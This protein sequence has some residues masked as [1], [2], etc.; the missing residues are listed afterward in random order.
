MIASSEVILLR[1][2]QKEP[3][4]REKMTES[5]KKMRQFVPLLAPTPYARST[6]E[7]DMDGRIRGAAQSSKHMLQE[8]Y[9]IKIRMIP[10][11]VVALHL[12]MDH[13]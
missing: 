10:V 8:N 12:Y 3:L 13:A 7:T 11:S 1:S 4:F 9:R 2:K 5:E 6:T